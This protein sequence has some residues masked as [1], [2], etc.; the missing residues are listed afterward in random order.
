M[1]CQTVSWEQGALHLQGGPFHPC[2]IVAIQ[3]FF[4][5][6]FY[7]INP[8]SY[9]SFGT[10]AESTPSSPAWSFSQYLKRGC[11]PSVLFIRCDP[12]APAILALTPHTLSSDRPSHS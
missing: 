11:K 10:N 7:D 12:T 5:L 3:R 4:I 2:G 9:C 1:S 6:H 8:G